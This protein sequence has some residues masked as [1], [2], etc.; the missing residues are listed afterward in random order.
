MASTE[1]ALTHPQDWVAPVAETGVD[2]IVEVPGS[3]SLTNRYLVLAALADSSSIVR[4]WLR[5]RDTLLMISALRA[6]GAG[7]DEVDG[8]LHITPI[9][10][11]AAGSPVHIDCGLAGTVMRFVPPLAAATGREVHIDGDPQARVRPMDV[12]IDSLTRLGAQVTS[13]TNSLPLTI[14]AGSAVRGGH[15][16]IDAS[17]S[18]QFVSGL[19]LTAPAMPL[20][21][22]LVHHGESVPSRT[23]IEMTLEVLADAGVDVTEPEPEHW[24]VEPGLPRGLDVQVEPDLSN[25]AAF[26]AAA[27]ATRGQI[28]IPDWPAHTTQAGDG[29]RRIAE[30]FGGTVDL[31]R[32][33]LTV[34]GPKRLRPVDLDLSAIGE[35]TPVVAALAAL[36]PGT[37]HLRGIGHLRGHETDRLSALRRELGAIGADV[38]EHPAALT[39]TGSRLRAGTWHTY[40][41]H[42]MVMAGA[43]IGLQVPGLVIENVGTVAKTLPQFAQLWEA[44]LDSKD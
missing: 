14:Q 18:S 30:A 3:K 44:M 40:H 5:S 31:D 37:S 12:T 1:T 25:A 4:G 13:E 19:L 35:L 43:V 34:R 16:E 36:T 26:L 6:L 32:S 10:L 38:I 7:I 2:A 33:G 22:D 27:L 17:A 9:D 42:R 11:A 8:E 24:V 28:T 23:H 29:F 20:G 41:D 15:L 39:I 21:I